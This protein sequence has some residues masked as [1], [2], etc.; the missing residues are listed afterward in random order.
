MYKVFIVNDSAP[1]HRRL[2]GSTDDPQVVAAAA[3]GMLAT[4]PEFRGPALR[5]MV[6]RRR[7]ALLAAI[8]GSN[9]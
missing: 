7:G 1:G 8:E 9:R 3:G 5:Q 6:N 2:V 4:L